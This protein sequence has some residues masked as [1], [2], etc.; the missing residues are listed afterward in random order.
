M[1]G[2]DNLQSEIIRE[3]ANPKNYTKVGYGN[4]H[5]VIFFY[6]KSGDVRLEQAGCWTATRPRHWP[7]FRWLHRTAKDTKLL[8][9]M[10]PE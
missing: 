5:D 7:T 10:L 2:K 6:S 4:I 8:H 1:F 3:K 9:F